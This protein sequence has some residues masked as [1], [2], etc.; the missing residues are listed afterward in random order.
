MTALVGRS[1]G[2]ATQGR[3]RP[4]LQ[5]DALLFVLAVVV[6]GRGDVAAHDLLT[7]F[8]HASAC[9][10]ARSKYRRQSCRNGGG[11]FPETRRLKRRSRDAA[12]RELIRTPAKLGEVTM[13]MALASELLE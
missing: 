9:V 6:G 13:R 8:D 3:P 12:E 2:Q 4:P 10:F 1:A 7:G 5:N 11:C